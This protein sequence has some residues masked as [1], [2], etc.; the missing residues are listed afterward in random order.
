[1]TAASTRTHNLAQCPSRLWC[2]FAT[3][4]NVSWTIRRFDLWLFRDAEGKAWRWRPDVVA[5]RLRSSLEK[6]ENFFF[7]NSVEST[8]KSS[9]IA[10]S[11]PC[12]VKVVLLLPSDSLSGSCRT[13]EIFLSPPSPA[14]DC[15]LCADVCE[16][17]IE[18]S[19]I[20]H[21]RLAS[22]YAWWGSHGLVCFS[23]VDKRDDL[24]IVW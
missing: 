16:W 18:L 2:S 10:L 7:K 11:S 12:S 14:M 23:L 4:A 6:D 8:W 13:N 21:R 19:A 17:P 3:S 20:D 5:E 22:L 1:M 15:K 9:P 24:G